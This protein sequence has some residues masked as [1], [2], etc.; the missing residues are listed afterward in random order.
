MTH[1]FFWR[2]KC[3]F[4]YIEKYLSTGDKNDKLLKALRTAVKVLLEKGQGNMDISNIT[5]SEH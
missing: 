5:V 1:T 2:P 3:E 4:L